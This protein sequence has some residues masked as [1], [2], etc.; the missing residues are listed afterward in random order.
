MQARLIPFLL[1]Y[2]RGKL[3]KPFSSRQALETWQQKKLQK[4][5]NWLCTKIPFYAG[6]KSHDLNDFPL[7]NKAL[8]MDNFDKLNTVGFTKE[9]V[10][11]VAIQSEH[12]RDFSPTINGISVGLSSGTSGNRGAFLV[13]P[14]EQACWAGA[15]FAKALPHGLLTKQRVALFLRANNNLYQ[16]TNGKRIQFKFFDLANPID[17][18]IKTLKNFSPTLLIAPPSV[19]RL[20]G[21]QARELRALEKIFSAAEVLEK[22]DEAILE[23]DFKQPIHQIYQCTEGFLGITCTHGNMHLNE[24][25]VHV[26]R[27]YIDKSSGRFVPVITDMYRKSQPIIRYE[28]N[29]VLVENKEPCQ[30]GSFMV[31]L[32]AIEGRC[33]D[34]FY[35]KH[36]NNTDLTPVFP[37]LISRAIIRSSD[38]IVSYEVV[39]KKNNKLSIY[40]KA[41]DNS[42]AIASRI[43]E[44]FQ[45]L[46]QRLQCETP[47]LEFN[48]VLPQR[49]RLKKLKRIRREI[50]I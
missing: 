22:L 30:C 45:T 33:D 44:E 9:E 12:T 42:G 16:S 20:I 2:A 43:S 10:F 35:F 27:K 48:E 18:N 37:G 1:S 31:R 34:V 15:I 23:K 21:P 26:E 40:L 17:K 46:C 47:K 32:D 38:N 25:I 13:S 4:H 41:S 19:L 24:D 29:D 36:L 11:R 49:N 28:L 7:M 50:A 3:T 14:F 39:Q 6:L 8:M 5:L